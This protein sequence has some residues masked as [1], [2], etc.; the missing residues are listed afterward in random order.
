[1][2]YILRKASR[3][4][5]KIRISLQ[6]S[7]GSGKT[8][9]SLLLARGLSTN[10]SDIALIDTENGSA[11]LYAHLGE[12]RTLTLSEPYSPENYVKAIGH[13]IQEG[14][15]VVI[16]DSL[17][18]CW[19]YLLRV[20][21]NMPGNS[22]ANWSKI[23]PRLDALVQT[24]LNSPVHVIV[25]HRTKHA[26]SLT[27]KNGKVVPEKIGLKAVQRDDIDYEFTTVFNLDAK[28]EAIS[29]KDRT[30]LFAHKTAFRINEKTGELIQSWCE[31][32]TET[33]T[34]L[35]D[36]IKTTKSLKELFDLYSENKRERDTFKR[37]FEE[38]KLKLQATNNQSVN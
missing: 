1:M 30:G 26:Y 7:S 31:T 15:Q 36:R 20:H 28:H 27:T 12:F 8:Y 33:T 10:W 22:F 4:Q 2:E 13:C 32:S 3:K 21:A 35:A 19:Q 16:I 38:Q 6:G 17:S 9:S 14:A 5:A 11:D 34:S 25:T 29:S 18:H 23:T 37:D 24:I